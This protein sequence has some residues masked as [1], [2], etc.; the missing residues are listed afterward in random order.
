MANKVQG[1]DLTQQGHIH[2]SI[3]KSVC[4]IEFYHPSHNSLP[5]KL[6]SELAQSILDN[7][8]NPDVLLILLKS[9]GDRTFC[10]GASF[11]ELVAISDEEQGKT[12]FQGFAKV[13]NAIRTCLLYTSPSPRDS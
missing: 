9:A 6:L 5:S 4:T 8:A 2:S 7:G 12:F 3:D 10:A 13:I 1:E 11:D